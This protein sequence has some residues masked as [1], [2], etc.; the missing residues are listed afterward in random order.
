M[1][2]GVNTFSTHLWFIE[3]LVVAYFVFIVISMLIKPEGVR[4]GVFFALILVLLSW[5]FWVGVFKPVMFN[6]TITN[7]YYRNAWFFVFLC[8]L[9]DMKSDSGKNA[10]SL[11][12]VGTGFCNCV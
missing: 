11:S 12:N 4:A 1:Y 2:Y 5:H 6:E 7:H 8:F 3:A 10:A 9:W